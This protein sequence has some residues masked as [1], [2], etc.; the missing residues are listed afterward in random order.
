MTPEQRAEIIKLP[1]VEVMARTIYGEAR[2]E[3]LPGMVAVAQVIINRSTDDRHRYGSGIVNVC[4]KRWQ[5]SCWN[6]G[7]LNLPI[8]MAPL[9]D[10]APAR[11]IAALAVDGL[12]IDNTNGSN[13][14]HAAGMAV[15]PYWATAGGVFRRQHVGNHI[16]YREV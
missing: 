6:D 8:L 1:D 14:Y 4:L 9:A 7:E 2:G 15:Y 13:L 5:F 11:I 16:F 10:I 3:G 12:L